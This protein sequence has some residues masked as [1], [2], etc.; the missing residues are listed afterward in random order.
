MTGNKD[1]ITGLHPHAISYVT[2]GDGAKGE[3]KGIWKLDCPRV[4]K[5]DKVLLLKGLTANLISIIQLCDQGLNVNFTKTECLITNKDS[6]V[7]MKGIRTKDNCYL[8]NSQIDYS[9]KCTYVKGMKMSISARGT[10]K[11]DERQVCGKCQTR[12]SHQK[13]RLNITSKGEKLMMAQ[14]DRRLDHMGEHVTSRMQS[15]VG[16]SLVGLGLQVKQIEGPMCLSQSK[17]AKR[18][19][20]KI[21]METVLNRVG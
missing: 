21:E 13:L 20:E 5:L 10:L 18:N 2:F 1:L 7:I 12:M 17:S 8:W 9:S 14:I 11:S 15:E 3:I 4:P 16:K 19:V 6:E